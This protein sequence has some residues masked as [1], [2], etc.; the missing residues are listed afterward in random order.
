MRVRLPDE[1]GALA[2]LTAAVA[3][4][5]GN[6]LAL[7][8]HG[9]DS[10]S[11]VD[12]MLVGGTAPA[13]E[14]S[15]VI[16]RRLRSTDPDA[17]QVVVADPHELVDVPTRALD[18][19]AGAA[20]PQDVLHGL[21]DLLHA[22]AVA[23][24]DADPD[25]DDGHA[26][27]VPAPPGAP[28]VVL[29]REWAPFTLTERA[30]AE[31]FLRA[32]AGPPQREVHHLMRQ[33]GSTLVA[34]PATGDEIVELAALLAACRADGS[35]PATEPSA[36][37]LYVLLRPRGGTCLLARTPGGTLVG[38]ASRGRPDGPAPTILVHPD[39]RDDRLTGWLR[40]TVGAGRAAE[41]S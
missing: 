32:T 30:R 40:D 19:A 35:G 28:P 38:A 11:V 37:G 6:I 33:D 13:G 20:A 10:R 31:A 23:P 2:R 22:D 29:R 41:C 1:S 17:V 4:A 5:G 15:R 36:A 39:H 16:R 34:G 27:A 7:S 3:D 14:L 25:P 26:L 8:V 24:A 21:R 18:L 9:Q 12:E